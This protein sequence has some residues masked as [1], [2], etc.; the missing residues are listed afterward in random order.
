MDSEEVNSSACVQIILNLVH[1]HCCMSNTEVAILFNDCLSSFVCKLYDNHCFHHYYQCSQN[2]HIY[3]KDLFF[4]NFYH[5][6]RKRKR[7]KKSQ[8]RKRR[9]VMRNLQRR[10]VRK[11]HPRKSLK[12]KKRKKRKQRKKTRR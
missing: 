1:C 4:L 10:K 8:R 2:S 5:L 6:Y 12:K 9:E 7:R 3:Y 11:N